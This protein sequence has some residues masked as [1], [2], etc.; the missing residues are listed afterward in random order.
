MILGFWLPLTIW[1][2]MGPEVSKN[3]FGGRKR[4]LGTFKSIAHT[5]DD[6]FWWLEQI[7]KNHEKSSF[8]SIFLLWAQRRK[9]D[10]NDD[11][12]WFFK[13][14]SNHQK[15]S[16]TVCAILL[17]VP[18]GLFRPPNTFFDT[19]GPIIGQIVRGSQKPKIMKNA[20][21]DENSIF[22]T[23]AKIA[24]NDVIWQ[25][26]DTWGVLD[27]FCTRNRY[28]NSFR[29]YFKVFWNFGFFGIFYLWVHSKSEP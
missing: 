2:I 11:F 29:S 19:S 24:Q 12:S 8:L 7:L 23:L 18:R 4:P 27:A 17:K 3:V 16:S 6:D 21:F 25:E 9:I 15:S 13:I 10:K 5:V 14:C 1:P 28:Q 26:M 20:N 22:H